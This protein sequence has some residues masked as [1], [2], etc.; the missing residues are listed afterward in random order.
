MEKIK[1][2]RL[3]SNWTWKRLPIETDDYP[4]SHKLKLIAENDRLIA[5]LTQCYNERFVYHI[6][7]KNKKILVTEITSTSIL[8]EAIDETS[9][10]ILG[11]IYAGLIDCSALS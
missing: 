6:W 10:A 2:L 5:E 7:D 9:E 8:D 4:L 11:F 1:E 3:L